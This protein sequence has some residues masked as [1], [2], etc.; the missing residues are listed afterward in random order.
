MSTFEGYAKLSPEE[1]DNSD[2][3]YVNKKI[4]VKGVGSKGAA[5]EQTCSLPLVVST[6]SFSMRISRY[7]AILI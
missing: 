4:L 6:C 1:I 2:A 3:R 5:M 7:V